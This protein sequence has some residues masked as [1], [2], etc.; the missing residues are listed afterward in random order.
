M[1]SYANT[2]IILIIRRINQHDMF[3]L[4][5]M[6]TERTIT[7][8]M[9]EDTFRHSAPFPRVLRRWEWKFR[10]HAQRRGIPQQRWLM[11]QLTIRLTTPTR[12]ARNQMTATTATRTHIPL[13]QTWR[14]GQQTKADVM[15][16]G[17]THITSKVEKLPRVEEAVWPM[18]SS[19]ASS[20]RTHYTTKNISRSRTSKAWQSYRA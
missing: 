20:H 3:Q 2:H 5:R 12:A 15:F 8:D 19:S 6:L 14:V 10:F 1:A 13:I 17:S 18:S 16:I 4:P 7:Q 11:K 9:L